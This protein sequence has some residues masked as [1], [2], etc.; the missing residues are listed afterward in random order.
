MVELITPGPSRV[1]PPCAVATSCGGCTWQHVDYQEQ[2]RQKREIVAHALRKVETDI[3]VAP[4]IPSP[5]PFHYRNRV[6]IHGKNG[7]WG[8][9]AAK[10]NQIVET[11]ECLIAEASINAQIKDLKSQRPVN[12]GTQRLEIVSNGQNSDGAFSQVNTAVNDLLLAELLNSVPP[13][14]KQIYD[15]YC[16]SGNFSLPIQ[17]RWP[18]CKVLGVESNRY[19]IQGAQAKALQQGLPVTFE[20]G[21]VEQSLP[22]L[23]P[24]A[25]V[26]IL[27]PPR[28]GCSRAVLD[29]LISLRPKKIIYISC[30]PMTL[31]RDLSLIVQSA[32][33]RILKIQPFDMFPQTSHVEIFSLLAFQ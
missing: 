20:A 32:P 18:N 19:A 14:P 10:S 13:F 15:L 17:Q 6:Q 27:D 4:V 16:G 9:L 28:T 26:V 1:D 5:N 12:E 30:D 22:L 7:T 29:G 8:F 31:A 21:D 24:E 23:T 33:Y 2:L 25:D 11:D 3:S